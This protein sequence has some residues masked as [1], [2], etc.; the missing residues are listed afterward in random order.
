MKHKY[1]LFVLLSIIFISQFGAS[2]YVFGD[3]EY[4]GYVVDD[5]SGE[6]IPDAKVTVYYRR[7]YRRYSSRWYITSGTTT[8][9]DGRFQL[10]MAQDRGY[11]FFVSHET[12]GEIDYVPYGVY[13]TIGVGPE[14]ETIR[15]WR[16]A[17]V[18]LEGQDFFIETSAI[19]D[20]TIRVL[21]PNEQDPID[22][23]EIN[24]YY[25]SGGSTVSTYLNKP[26]GEVYVPAGRGFVIRV[27]A[28]VEKGGDQLSETIFI[29]E[30][31]ERGLLEGELTSVDLQDRILPQ[32][33]NKIFNKTA[34][35]TGLI[36][37]K[38]EQG[39]FLAV[40]R[41]KLGSAESLTST[42]QSRMDSGGFEEAFTSLREAYVILTDL[43]NA[44]TSM[45]GDAERSVFILV[46]FIALT[47]QVVATLLNDDPV[48][49]TAIGWVVFIVL[50]AVLY[51]LHPGAQIIKPFDII[52]MGAYSL[53][54][55]SLAGV[56]IPRILQRGPETTNASLQHMAVPILSISKR[57]LRRRKLRFLLTLTSVL[58]LVA[59]FI[60]LTSFTSG[61]G[62]SLE[63]TGSPIGKD[64]I[65]I[66]T[67]DPPP[68]QDTSPYSG[69]TGVSG[70]LPLDF[71]L[72]KWFDDADEVT[73]VIPRYENQ[74]QRQYREG[75]S[76][77]AYID[78]IHVFGILA[79]DAEYEAEVNQ[80]D[81]AIVEGEYMGDR[82][83]EAMVSLGMAEKLD[84]SVGDTIVMR[85]QERTH[86]LTIVALLDDEKL[87]KLTDL[88][89]D[90]ILPRKII[91]FSRIEYDGPDLIVEAIAP[92]SPD[93]VV[94]TNLDSSVN[95]TL[96]KLTRL[97]LV[98][99]PEVDAV[100]YARTTALNRGFRV[101]ASTGSGVYLAQLTSYFGGKGLPIVIPWMIV[102][103]NVIVT[104]MNAYFERRHEVMIFSS[105][106]MNPHHISAIFLAEAAVTGILGGCI[107]YLVGL[108]AYKFI[109]LVTPAL[110]VKQKVS[111]V[112]SLGAI[113]ISLAAVL[114]GGLIA[115]RNSVSITPSLTRRW[116]VETQGDSREETRI[117][118]PIHAF[119]EELEEYTD[120]IE[121][122][123]RKGK[124]GRE[125]AVRVLK[126]TVEDDSRVFSFIYSSAS[127]GIASLYT[128][129]RVVIGPAVDGVYSTTLFTDG[130][131][132]S[133][134]KS[135]GFMRRVCLGWSMKRE[136]Q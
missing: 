20:I 110:Q 91:E 44:V 75:Y 11:L 115:L 96:L 42:A 111:A 71:G 10:D 68:T 98:L 56:A 86:E 123:L 26:S 58:L 46:V 103:L 32:S 51:G 83:G 14:E 107:G 130:D 36:L 94:V 82:I 66:R 90:I 8:D 67:P 132:D 43:E 38:E 17:T 5:V 104:M 65:M 121:E 109:Y 23:G 47:S 112:W 62:L 41:Q 33:F 13:H 87:G 105:I 116:K 100:E 55:V 69:G 117:D 49:K 125:M 127:G 88:D 99:E 45:V 73:E 118:L 27:N 37:D 134:K 6:P 15:L 21:E 120:F 28:H 80:L 84:V 16:S 74:P 24:L 97:N 54:S 126:K 63:N 119:A 124:N 76:P 79:V 52:R 25:G 135:G 35:L 4:V 129:N 108:G 95:M 19:P 12:E 77:I 93:E 64:G 114:I 89:G 50:L 3:P 133:V 81:S 78:G 136:G 85:A 31:I 48:K 61:F 131:D 18:S 7:F 113:G 101:W 39:F 34:G 128:K 72:T 29:D 2:A 70:P 1:W 59:S 53:V 122:R 22:Y 57:S 106:G 60:S 102:V 9:E 30:Y 40:E 92:C